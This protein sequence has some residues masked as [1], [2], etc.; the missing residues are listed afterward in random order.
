[1]MVER[2]QDTHGRLHVEGVQMSAPRKLDVATALRE[3]LEDRRLRIPA[4]DE[5]RRD[6]HS[7]RAEAG[8]TD[9]HADRF[10]AIALAC[11]AAADTT[12]PFTARTTNGRYSGLA[13]YGGD[14]DAYAIDRRLNIVNGGT[15]WSGWH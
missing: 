3:V 2:L 13:A 8:A 14:N 9:G 12:G 6:L 15:D 4:D 5:L 11:A 10:W 1:M 7:V